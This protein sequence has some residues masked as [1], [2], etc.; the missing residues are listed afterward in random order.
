MSKDFKLQDVENYFQVNP[1]IKAAMENDMIRKRPMTSHSQEIKELI[2]EFALMFSLASAIRVSKILK[3]PGKSSIKAACSPLLQVLPYLNEQNIIQHLLL[4]KEILVRTYNVPAEQIPIQVAID[5]TSVT[6][7]LST[8]KVPTVSLDYRLIYGLH[9]ENVQ[10]TPLIN[11]VKNSNKM[12]SL[13]V[14]A[15]KKTLDSTT[16]PRDRECK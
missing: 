4:Y 6:G 10:T 5:G 8:R 3:G 13:T 1:E 14:T 2:Y 15:D 12:E 11:L 16:R 9:C 7:K